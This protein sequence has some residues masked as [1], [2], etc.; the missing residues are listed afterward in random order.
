MF[1]SRRL[2]LLA[3][4]SWLWMGL[5]AVASLGKLGT[6]IVQAVALGTFVEAVVSGSHS[7]APL[8]QT[9]AV[10]LGCGLAR[11]VLSYAAAGTSFRS[12]AEARRRIRSIM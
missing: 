12:S 5:A 11:F 7:I 2:F 4:P 9:A 6:T 3:K 1:L 8:M 10:L